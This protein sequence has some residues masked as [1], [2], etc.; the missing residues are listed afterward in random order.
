[1][2]WSRCCS[3]TVVFCTVPLWQLPQSAMQS[4]YSELIVADRARHALDE[5]RRRPIPEEEEEDG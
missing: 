1:M 5:H 3:G 2:F 4:L